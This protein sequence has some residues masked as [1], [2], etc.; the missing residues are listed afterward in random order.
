MTVRRCSCDSAVIRVSI[1][2]KAKRLVVCCDNSCTT[3]LKFED[4]PEHLRGIGIQS[5]ESTA[6]RFGGSCHFSAADGL[7]RAMVIMNE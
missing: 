5:I 7:F 1:K 2:H 3:A 6:D 4:M